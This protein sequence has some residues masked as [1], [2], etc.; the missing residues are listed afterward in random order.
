MEQN[1][2]GEVYSGSGFQNAR[3]VSQNCNSTLV[4]GKKK[5][6][7]TLNLFLIF[8]IILASIASGY[9]LAKDRKNNNTFSDK[10]L[11]F[12]SD[13]G[14]TFSYPQSFKITSSEN[15]IFLSGTHELVLKTEKTKGKS[16]LEIT[17]FK[18]PET[19]TVDGRAGYKVNMEDVVYYFFPL[20]GEDYLKVESKGDGRISDDIVSSI[21][22]AGPFRALVN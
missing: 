11:E 12:S 10:W 15:N 18:E 21:R 6:F 19:L 13:K 14:F 7:S 4:R 1:T 5:K 22:F 17:A 20:F 16:L 8:V 9:F 3:F 2:Q